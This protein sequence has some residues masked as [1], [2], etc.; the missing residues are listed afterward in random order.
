MSWA[1]G[2]ELLGVIDLLDGQAVHAVAGRRHS[3]RPLKL[4]NH[5]DGD[6]LALVEYYLNAGASGI[7]VADLDG[8]VRSHADWRV[9]RA[10]AETRRPLFI[11]V[12]LREP[13]DLIAATRRL[14]R[15]NE[16]TW[17]VATETCRNLNSW[18][19]WRRVSNRS[20]LAI[21]ID[22]RGGRLSGTQ[23]R[24]HRLVEQA[25]LAGINRFVVLDLAAVGCR[26]GPITGPFCR[27]V[28][29]LV[30]RAMVF[31]GGGVRN[32]TD[33]QSLHQ[34]GCRGILIATALLPKAFV[35]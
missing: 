1:A 27:Q 11:D 6:P 17:I 19:A 8:I 31:S 21:G 18:K 30:P 25:A 14:D 5:T 10:I 15:F 13:T 35:N 29:R 26:R 12:G 20:T 32:A 3:Y 34:C 2:F 23:L 7:Y 22:L 28:R 16:V 4:P 9:L 33:M 24:P